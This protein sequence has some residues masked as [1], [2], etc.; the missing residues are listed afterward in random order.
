MR[1]VLQVFENDQ[2]ARVNFVQTV[3][4]LAICKHR[5]VGGEERDRGDRCV[6]ELLRVA[7]LALHARGARGARVVQR[8]CAAR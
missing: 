2:T 8:G 4:E 5:A 3:A 6:L 1:A 7:A